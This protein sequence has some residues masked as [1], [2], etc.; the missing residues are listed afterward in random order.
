MT[1]KIDLTDD[2]GNAFPPP[3]PGSDVGRLIYLL[4]YARKRGFQLG[5][6]VQIGDVVV[7][8]RDLALAKRENATVPETDIWKEHGHDEG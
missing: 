3:D 8:V 4:E 7:Q 6:M 1:R 2:D 5:P